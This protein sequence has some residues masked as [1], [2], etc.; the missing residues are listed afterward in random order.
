MANALNRE[1][2]IWAVGGSLLLFLRGRVE[3]FNDIDI[4]VDEE[5]AERA[6][7]ILGNLGYELPY[8]P[9]VKFATRHFHEFSI[10]GVCVDLLAGFVIISDGNQY[11]C[12]LKADDI[13]E[14]IEVSGAQI[15]LHSLSEWHRYYLLM[16]RNDRANQ[17]FPNC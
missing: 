4:M 16:G 2:I 7:V 6:A 11:E 5:Q 1:G 3:S 12:P 10:D 8:K 14:N 15:P 9:N 13:K 17:I